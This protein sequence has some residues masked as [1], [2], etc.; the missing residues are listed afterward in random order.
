MLAEHESRPRNENAMHYESAVFADPAVADC[1]GTGTKPIDRSLKTLL[2]DERG[3]V[4]VGLGRVF[5]GKELPNEPMTLRNRLP[6][7]VVELML[8]TFILTLMIAIVLLVGIYLDD[9]G[10]ERFRALTN[11][12]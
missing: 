9:L 11:V 5:T 1:A 2:H 12:M 7:A 10:F 4:Q 3:S 8:G 6:A